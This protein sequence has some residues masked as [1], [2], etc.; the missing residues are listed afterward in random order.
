MHRQYSQFKDHIVKA[1]AA[2]R[3]KQA[4]DVRVFETKTYTSLAF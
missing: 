3:L 4:D 2:V 1:I